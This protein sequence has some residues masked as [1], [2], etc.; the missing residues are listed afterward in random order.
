MV[1]FY[2]LWYTRDGSFYSH[3][4]ISKYKLTFGSSAPVQSN[5]Y[6]SKLSKNDSIYVAGFYGIFFFQMQNRSPKSRTLAIYDFFASWPWLLVALL[7]PSGIK[8]IYA[9]CGN[10]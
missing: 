1:S 5:G 3:F 4:Y 10:N 2:L 8:V 7:I 9:L 6:Q